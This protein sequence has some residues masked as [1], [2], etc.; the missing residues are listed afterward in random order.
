MT[1]LS[2]SSS[3]LSGVL[4]AVF[5]IVI[6]IFSVIAHEVAHGAIAERL[7]DPTARRAGRITLN[8]IRHIDP[9]GSI[10]LPLLLYLTTSGA[11]MFGWA[12]P[13]P[14]NPAN[15]RDPK[16]GSGIIAAAGPLTNITVAIVFGILLRIL[17]IFG[18]PA[19]LMLSVFLNMIILIN[20]VL[21]VFNLIP[22]P[23]LDG[24]GVL[25]S[26]LPPQYR[27]VQEFL[28]RYQLFLFLIFIF[29][30]FG[31][32]RPVIELIFSWLAY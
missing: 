23:P 17:E 11:F 2:L 21:A 4:I 32:I 20:V 26:L 27:G 13:V 31:L 7:G 3:Q 1:D 9:F 25:F 8:P 22:I 5:Q 28:I 6:L 30:G 24:S 15:L 18:F 12:R 10:I 14:Y 19:P 16:L 29:F